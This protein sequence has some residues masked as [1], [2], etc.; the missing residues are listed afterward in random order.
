MGVLLA[1][2]GTLPLPAQAQAGAGPR[3]L[4]VPEK[5]A[6]LR[7]FK[8][9]AGK[10]KVATNQAP[11]TSCQIFPLGMG[12]PVHWF[13]LGG[14]VCSVVLDVVPLVQAPVLLRLA[15]HDAAT[16]DMQAADGGANASIQ[17]ELARTEN[18][19]LKRGWCASAPE[20]PLVCPDQTTCL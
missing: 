18:T 14:V 16:F 5:Q 8:K 13:F 19:G 20:G 10:P 11:C 2:A 15:F 9:A 4:S 17:Y 7:A 12:P 3:E 6:V 1:T